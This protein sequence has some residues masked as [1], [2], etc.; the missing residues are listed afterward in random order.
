[1]KTEMSFRSD[2]GRFRSEFQPFRADSVRLPRLQAHSCLQSIHKAST[3][4][5]QI[6]K[7]KQRDQLGRVF[8]QTAIANFRET[9]LTLDDPKW[10]LDLG[11]NAGLEVLYLVEHG[12]Q[13]GVCVQQLSLAR[14]HGD[15]PLD[16]RGFRTPGGALVAGVGEHVDFLSMQQCVTLGDVI[17]VGRCPD[18]GVHQAGVR[19]HTNVRLHP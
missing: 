16:S 14:A 6:A 19:I 9:E 4:H 18:D 5:P 7:R 1:M 15:M 17:D 8:H 2:S 11:A 12:A 3:G 13:F 10:M